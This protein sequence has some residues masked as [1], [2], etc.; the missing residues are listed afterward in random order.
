MQKAKNLATLR[1][2][3]QLREPYADKQ[4]KGWILLKNGMTSAIWISHITVTV[5][6]LLLQIT[7]SILK[8]T[9]PRFLLV[10]HPKI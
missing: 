4:I 9:T 10:T 5:N 3:M 2:N 8:K 7:T 1:Q 6:A